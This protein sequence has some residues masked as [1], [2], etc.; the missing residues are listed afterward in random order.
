MPLYWHEVT[1]INPHVDPKY[2]GSLKVGQK[3]GLNSRRKED[4][5]PDDVTKG[6]IVAVRYRFLKKLPEDFSYE[7]VCAELDKPTRDRR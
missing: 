7:Q 1:E 2:R 3:V 5:A 4:L 6:F